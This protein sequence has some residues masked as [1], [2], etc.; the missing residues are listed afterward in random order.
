MAPS[1]CLAFAT[2]SASPRK[3]RVALL[4]RALA[5][6]R[7]VRAL[8]S[9]SPLTINDT[10]AFGLMAVTAALIAS[11][12]LAFFA[13]TALGKTAALNMSLL[14]MKMRSASAICLTA[15]GWCS[16]WCRPCS[17]SIKVTTPSKRYCAASRVS[18]TKVCTTGAGSARP[19]V[20]MTTRSKSTISPARRWANSSRKVSCM[21]VRTEQQMQP[22]ASRVMFSDDMVTRSWSMPISPISLITTAT[23]RMSGCLTSLEISVVLPLPRKP[24][25]RVTGIFPARGSRSKFTLFLG[26]VR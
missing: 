26:Y 1:D 8:G 3:L 14:V 17:A 6:P 23:R 20:S 4:A 2:C 10:P 19:V 5:R 25:M 21:S 22:L 12:W 9:T 13:S 11:I 15:S 18:L 16:S 24:V 7:W